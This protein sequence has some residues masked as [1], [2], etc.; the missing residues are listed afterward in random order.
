MMTCEQRMFDTLCKEANDVVAQEP[1]L[2]SAMHAQVLACQDLGDVLTNIMARKLANEMLPLTSLLALFRQSLSS[3]PSLIG[4]AVRDID[5]VLERDAAS[6]L[7]LNV[8]LYQKGFIA[9]QVHRVAHMLWHDGRHM[10]AGMLQNRSSEVFGVDIHPAC[11]IGHGVMLDHATGIVIGETASIGN[12]VSILQGVTLG[13]TGKEAGDRHPK[14]HHGVLIGASATV[15]GNISI[16]SGAQ[17][18]AGSVV[19]DD[20]APHTT[21]VGV[22]ARRVGRP[23]CP[24]PSVT[25][26]HNA[27]DRDCDALS[28]TGSRTASSQS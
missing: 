21:V 9:L 16:G 23:R 5:A 13:G 22:P 17:I 26:E 24:S 14:V 11:P 27:F 28:D 19:L 2:A 4:E 20:V 8:V 6:T 12:N 7:A 18:G 1:L 3:T 10:M 15:L 25:L